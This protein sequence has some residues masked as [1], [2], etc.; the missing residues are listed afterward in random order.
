MRFSFLGV[1]FMILLPGC[2]RAPKRDITMAQAL[3]V[4]YMVNN[5]LKYF[6]VTNRKEVAAI[7][8]MIDVDEFRPNSASGND[9]TGIVEF[10]MPDRLRIRVTFVRPDKLDRNDGGQYYLKSDRFYKEI[11]RLATQTEGRI[12]DVLENN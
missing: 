4:G 6:S 10:T 8:A 1:V 3:R 2:D 11:C 12:I 5:D 7:V 9:A